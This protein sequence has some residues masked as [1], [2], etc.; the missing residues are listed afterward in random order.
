M[1]QLEAIDWEEKQGSVQ[2]RYREVFEVWRDVV[3]ERGMGGVP[4]V[5]LAKVD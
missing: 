5:P 3:Q 4:K 1:S 2:E